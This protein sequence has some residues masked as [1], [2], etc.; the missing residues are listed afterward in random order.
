[1]QG[2]KKVLK[3]TEVR[4]RVTLHDP[5]DATFPITFLLYVNEDVVD[6]YS[7]DTEIEHTFALVSM[8]NCTVCAQIIDDNGKKSFNEQQTIVVT[9]LKQ[10]RDHLIDKINYLIDKLNSMKNGV[11]NDD[12][13]AIQNK[14]DLVHNAIW[15]LEPPIIIATGDLAANGT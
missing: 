15:Q 2:I 1:M 7:T 14:Q 4:I 11:I 3:G 8:E 12:Y 5:D 10:E 9:T 13:F 6:K